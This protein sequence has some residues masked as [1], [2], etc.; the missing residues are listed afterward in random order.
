MTLAAHQQDKLEQ[1]RSLPANV[2][3]LPETILPDTAQA[4][5][6]GAPISDNV[7]DIHDFCSPR[8]HMVDGEKNKAATRNAQNARILGRMAQHRRRPR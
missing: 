6:E 5:T 1:A 3:P 4:T 8:A 2:I 7:A